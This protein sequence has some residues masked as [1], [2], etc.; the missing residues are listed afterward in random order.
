MYVFSRDRALNNQFRN[1]K[2]DDYISYY[3]VSNVN[4]DKYD[5]NVL[6]F[7]L[8]L[9][10]VQFYAHCALEVIRTQR[11]LSLSGMLRIFITFMGAF[12]VE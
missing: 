6:C 11:S 2:G 7:S 9:L 4:D 3:D 8:V 10:T 5:R 1:E 12:Y